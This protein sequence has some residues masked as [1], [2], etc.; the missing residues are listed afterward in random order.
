MEC[1]ITNNALTFYTTILSEPYYYFQYYSFILVEF[2]FRKFICKL[3]LNTQAFANVHYLYY[4]LFTLILFIHYLFVTGGLM[5][6]FTNKNSLFYIQ[7][8]LK[9]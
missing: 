9:L 6:Y 8:I 5:R 2:V 4:L 1:S 3:K 7:C